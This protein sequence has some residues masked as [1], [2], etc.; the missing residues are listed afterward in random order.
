MDKSGNEI[1]GCVCVHAHVYQKSQ[2]GYNGRW[3]KRPLGG[4]SHPKKRLQ[5]LALTIGGLQAVGEAQCQVGLG[6][7]LPSFLPTVDHH[8]GKALCLLQLQRGE[9]KVTGRVLLALAYKPLT[10]I[11][12]YHSELSFLVCEQHN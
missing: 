9:A 3:N 12:L 8:H 6:E 5:V 7:E 2:W 1:E 11:S 10:V 4:L